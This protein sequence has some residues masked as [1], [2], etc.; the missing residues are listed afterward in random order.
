MIIPMPLDDIPYSLRIGVN[1][2][3]YFN[4]C[5]KFSMDFLLIM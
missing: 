4:I 1:L 3:F 2:V 5:Q